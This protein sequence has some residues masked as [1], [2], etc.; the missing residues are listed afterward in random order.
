[1][2]SL[3]GTDDEALRKVTIGVGVL[4]EVPESWTVQFAGN[5]IRNRFGLTRGGF[6]VGPYPIIEND[7]LVRN[8]RAGHLVF[9]DFCNKSK[10]N[11]KCR[12]K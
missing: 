11:G 2:S 10:S 4:Y 12:L 7:N 1:M 6:N 8:V 3:L 5:Y 9:S